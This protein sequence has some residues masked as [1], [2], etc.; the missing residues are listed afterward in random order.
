MS[1]TSTAPP[2]DNP[3][4]GRRI[5][6]LPRMFRLTAEDALAAAVGAPSWVQ[7]RRRLEAACERARR[8]IA[9]AWR[10]TP[11]EAWPAAAAAWDL[12][13]PNREIEAYNRW[14]PVERNLPMT[15]EFRD[16]V[17]EDGRWRPLPRLDAAWVLASF[18]AEGAGT[19][20][21]TGG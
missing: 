3:Q 12:S 1:P 13:K 10:L 6:Y 19:D 4:R 17:D 2:P 7:R 21:G 5:E 20:L 15:P 18:P 8:Q 16:F 11:P 9:R 14:Y